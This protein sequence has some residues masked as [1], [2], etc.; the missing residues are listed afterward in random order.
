[1]VDLT[2]Q[3]LNLVPAG[4]NYKALCP[5][6]HEK[7]PSFFIMPDKNTFACYGCN[8]YGD[9]FTFVQEIENLSFPEAVKFLIERFSL[10]I[11][12]PLFKEKSQQQ[13]SSLSEINQLAVSF[14]KNCLMT[15]KEGQEA[16]QYLKN[17]NIS[18]ATIE[19]FS[20]GYAENKWDSL[21]A[22]LKKNGCNLD[23]AVEL[24][25]VIKNDKNHFYDRFRGRVM[26]PIFS[27]TGT[28]LAFGGRTIID[29]SSK[30]INSPDSPVYKKGKHLY[31][32]HITKSK[33]RENKRIIL[34]E[35]YM[36]FIT[37][38][39]NGIEYT[40]A[41]LGT[42]LTDDQVYLLKRFADTV[43]FSYD[44]DNAG[45]NATLR[46]IEKTLEQNLQSRVISIDQAKDPD[47]FIKNMG[48]SS[49]L[50]AME[51]SEDGFHFFL[52]TI[53]KDKNISDP[54]EKKKITDQINQLLAHMENQIVR[55][56]FREIAADFLGIESGLFESYQKKIFPDTELQAEKLQVSPAEKMFLESLLIY[57][58]FI[59]EI[60]DIMN[61][62]ICSVLKSRNLL[63]Q[64]LLCFN[65]QAKNFTDYK[66][67]TDALTDNEKKLFIEL[68]ERLS[69]LP[70]DKVIHEKRIESCF[71]NFHS[72]LNKKMIK[73]IN[74][75]IKVAERECNKPELL[76]LMEKKNKYMKD[77]YQ[78]NVLIEN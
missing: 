7:T 78:K 3:Y 12:Q 53:S 31:G 45:Q 77:K 8:K 15:G 23:L 22:Y 33:I 24:G 30:Y 58:E 41:S 42:A 39:Q 47:E 62:E 40:A 28:A 2:S 32:L 11:S 37:L 68:Q 76:S 70:K 6:H 74:Q 27:D 29:D 64:L 60:C 75:R 61:D 38:Y 34:V 71:L 9:I 59:G 20:V 35:G 67:I 10:P 69:D 1:M 50:H 52:K 48:V 13:K 65:H 56:G 17:R 51:K 16:L 57:P 49:F 21:T 14:F 46:G 72:L 4:K 36:D 73:E 66:Q 19:T 5:F 63:K 26:F 25:L 55:N 44:M 18:L 54:L 43:Y